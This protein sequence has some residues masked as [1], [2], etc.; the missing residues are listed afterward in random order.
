MLGPIWAGAWYSLEGQIQFWQTFSGF[1]LFALVLVCACTDVKWHRIPNWS[2]YPA[3][4]WAFAINGFAS[5]QSRAAPGWLGAIG[6]QES[7]LGFA[8]LF[9]S[10][11]IVFS[12]TG[13]GAG[14]VKLIGCLGAFLGFDRG[15][16]AVAYSFVVAGAVLACWAIWTHGPLRL[17]RAIGG[18]LGSLM[19]PLWIAPPVEEDRQLLQAK[20]PLGPFFAAGTL[21]VLT[22]GYVRALLPAAAHH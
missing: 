16:N 21:L 15:I 20:V 6:I 17:L 5:L 10:G 18:S 19:L 8:V 4:L 14:D 9:V 1:V 2:T 7:L 3:V 22:E 12:I 11:L 13:G